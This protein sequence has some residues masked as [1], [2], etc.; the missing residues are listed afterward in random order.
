MNFNGIIEFLA[1]AENQG[2]SAAARRLGISTSQVSRQVSEL[3]RRLG[4]ELVARTTR[5]VGLTVA[6]QAYYDRCRELVHGF[7][8][9]NQQAS[10]SRLE[11]EGNLRISAA[12]E[13]AELQLVPALIEFA[14]QYPKLKL[15]LEFNV[16][17][18]DFVNDG[19]DFAIRYGQLK[20]SGLIARKLIERPLKV[21]ASPA[22]LKKNKIPK[23]PKALERHACL[24]T[25]SDIW[26]FQQNGEQIQVK[27]KGRWQS[28]SARSIVQA[29]QAG[30]GVAYLPENSFGSALEE[31]TL[32]PIL[33]EFALPAVPSW[34]VYA[35]R[36]YLPL[37]ARV[38]IDFLL[39]YFNPAA[40]TT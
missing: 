19:I 18:T 20:D 33:E 11:L 6:G 36:Q 23:N 5:S 9:A 3:E 37:R 12:G 34:I 30:L 38:A 1:V 31:G 28:Q 21:A 32:V 25:F 40:Q 14:Q 4:V 2:F 15:H 39:T 7:E 29:C 16:R 24:I 26:R 10:S 27:V 35:N 13:F 17:H 22:Y 8:I